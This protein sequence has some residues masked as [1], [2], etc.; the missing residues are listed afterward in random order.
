MRFRWCR[1]S[2][3]NVPERSLN[4]FSWGKYPYVLSLFLFWEISIRLLKHLRNCIAPSQH[5]WE[6]FFWTIN[7][8]I[9]T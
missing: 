8:N 7:W 2:F 5:L 6:S 4:C 1:F 3:L 9:L